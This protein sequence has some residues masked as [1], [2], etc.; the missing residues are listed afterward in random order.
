VALQ[1]NRRTVMLGGAALA[2]NFVLGGAA[3][4]LPNSTGLLRPPGG[5]DEERFTGSCIKCYRC[6]SVCPEQVITTVA[7]EDGLLNARTPSL[8]FRQGYCSFCNAC[9]EVCPT[10]ALTDFDPQSMKIGVA[11][12]SG[13]ACI[14][15]GLC[16][17]ECEYEALTW[18]EKTRLPVILEEQCNGCGACESVCPSASYGYFKGSRRPAI[19]ISR[20]SQ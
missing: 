8:D 18:D 5:Q 13:D 4:L 11:V 17:D 6:R 7:L 20:E 2:V 3:V 9:V 1:L 19:S 16:P 12:L 10:A 15:C 14:N